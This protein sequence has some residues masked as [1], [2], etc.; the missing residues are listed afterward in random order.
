MHAC[1][2]E[3][4]RRSF[5]RLAGAGLSTAALGA[6]AN[7]LPSHELVQSQSAFGIDPI[8]RVKTDAKRAAVTVLSWDTEGGSRAETNLL[9]M[10]CPLTLRIR[11]GGNW[12]VGTDLH[13]RK[14]DT[15]ESAASYTLVHSP[16]IELRWTIHPSPGQLTMTLSGRGSAIRDVET[17]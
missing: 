16:G 8:L 2:S 17:L 13:A 14:I 10:N 1:E 7:S 6:T 5:L 9:R 4:D 3:I 15:V 11:V 12:S